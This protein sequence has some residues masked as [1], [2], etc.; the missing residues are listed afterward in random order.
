MGGTGDGP[1]TWKMVIYWKIPLLLFF[2]FMSKTITPLLKIILWKFVTAVSYTVGEPNPDSLSTM[3]S[4]K[5]VRIG[6]F[7]SV[8][9]SFSNQGTGIDLGPADPSIKRH[10][11]RYFRNRLRI[12]G[13][14]IIIMDLLR[15][16]TSVT[17]FLKTK[18]AKVWK[19]PE[20]IHIAQI[21]VP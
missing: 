2:V 11:A 5:R 10:W 14:V 17:R 9:I 13:G 16:L 19:L 8:Q 12:V 7:H 18:C 20:C 6:L 15:V 21:F 1:T 3:H 4:I